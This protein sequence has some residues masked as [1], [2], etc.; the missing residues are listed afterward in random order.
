MAMQE[1][2]NDPRF[3]GVNFDVFWRPFQLNANAPKGKGVNKMEMYLEKFGKARC[4]AMLPQMIQTGLSVGIR[5]S[6]GGFTGNTF[7]SHR[8][9]WKARKEGGSELQDKVVESLFKAYF[10]EEKSIGETS[11]LVECAKR[12]GMG[13]SG[14]REFLEDTNGSASGAKE[15]QEELDEYRRNYRVSGVPF[16]VF[17]DKYSMSGAQPATEILSVFKKLI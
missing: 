4:D 11:V 16:F 15:V 2:R 8:L 5:F 13:E 9:I 14:V 7:D 6:Y 3:E 17:N 12:A 1:A 10:E